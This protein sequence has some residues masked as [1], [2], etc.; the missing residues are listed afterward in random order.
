MSPHGREVRYSP[1]FP[2]SAPSSVALAGGSKVDKRQAHGD[3]VTSPHPASPLSQVSEDPK[4]YS[5]NVCAL[6]LTAGQAPFSAV[7]CSVGSV[8]VAPHSRWGEGV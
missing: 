2:L 3:D 7:S 5:H 1:R 4:R 8:L 6:T